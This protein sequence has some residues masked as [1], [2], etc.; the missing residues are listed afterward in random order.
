MDSQKLGEGGKEKVLTYA[1]DGSPDALPPVVGRGA[2]AVVV[3][4][5]GVAGFVARR[6][7]YALGDAEE[8]VGEDHDQLVELA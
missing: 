4:T 2:G 1:H 7:G 3:K 6:L 5:H 8:L